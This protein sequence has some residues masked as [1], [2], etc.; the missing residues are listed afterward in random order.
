MTLDFYVNRSDLV[1]S[2]HI[3]MEGLDAERILDE[4][5][6]LSS[7]FRQTEIGPVWEAK[8]LKGQRYGVKEV[9]FAALIG[10]DK[11]IQH[12]DKE[13]RTQA[14]LQHPNLTRILT[15]YETPTRYLLLQELP[16]GR[17]LEELIAEEGKCTEEDARRIFQ[18]VVCG[19]WYLHSYG[20]CHR[21]LQLSNII[22]DNDGRAKICDF[23]VS[24]P[25]VDPET[26]ELISIKTTPL[27]SEHFM[28]PEVILEN[29]RDGSKVDIWALGV[30][31]YV[32][33]TGQYP[34][35][36]GLGDDKHSKKAR[37]ERILK[38][39]PDYPVMSTELESLLRSIFVADPDER[40]GINDI[41]D[42]S[43]V[44]QGF[45]LIRGLPMAEF[46][47]EKMVKNVDDPHPGI[48]APLT[49]FQLIGVMNPLTLERRNPV[50]S[51]TMDSSELKIRNHIMN[52]QTT[53]C[54][55]TPVV[56]GIIAEWDDYDFL[57]TLCP[58]QGKTIVGVEILTVPSKGDDLGSKLKAFAEWLEKRLKRTK[59]KS[60]REDRIT[61][62][63]SFTFGRKGFEVVNEGDD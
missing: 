29:Q 28:A 19:V 39:S 25:F 38:A 53:R 55:F 46:D 43:W 61:A 60:P 44:R 23:G 34:F 15:V 5:Y 37:V 35:D 6:Q 17:T 11:E 26:R 32:L 1:A 30:L 59:V 14:C 10:K 31:L 13:I 12:L 42:D 21:D 20:L 62:W 33:V 40:P 63:Q 41:I 8:D 16:T 4:Q 2:H 52:L 9:L 36:D 48:L 7:I 45:Q 22:V 18:D 49:I 57:V 51:F 47:G 24:T 27:G 3:L 58:L 50:T 56:S 54:V